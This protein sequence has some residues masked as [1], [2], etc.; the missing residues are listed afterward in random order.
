MLYAY[1]EGFRYVNVTS[2]DELCLTLTGTYDRA[3]KFR[4]QHIA[5]ASRTRPQRWSVT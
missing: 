1:E 2:F 4:F 3:R 5:V